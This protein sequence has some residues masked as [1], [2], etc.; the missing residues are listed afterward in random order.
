MGGLRPSSNDASEG[1]VRTPRPG[2][3][4]TFGTVAQE[5]ER[6]FLLDRAPGWLANC[7]STRIEQGYLAL[8]DEVEVRLRRSGEERML[9]V[10]RGR[11]EVRE[12]IE[13][14]LEGRQ[15]DALWPLTESRRLAKT[16]YVVQLGKD[17][18]AEVDVFEN[19]LEG[20]VLAEVEFDEEGGSRGFR[21]PAWVREEVTGDERYAGRSLAL[22]GSGTRTA[23]E[24]AGKGGGAGGSKARSYR[25][26]KKEPVAKGV[27]RIARGRA[28]DAREELSGAIDGDDLAAA[29]HAARKDMKKLRAVLRLVR[30]GLGDEVFRKENRR[31]RDAARLLAASRDA[32]VKVETLDALEERFDGDMPSEA[33]RRWRAT[34]E[35]EREEIIGA[36]QGEM[37]SRIDATLAALEAGIAEIPKWPLKTDSWELLEPGLLRSYRR[38]RREWKRTR[39]AASVESVHE[40]RKRVKDLWYQ[41]RIVRKAWPAAIGATADQAHELADLLGDHH[42]LA[43]LAD[44]L[45]GREAVGDRQALAALVERRQQELLEEALELAARLLAEKPKAFRARFKAYWQA[46]RA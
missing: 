12:E 9:A 13:V 29:I 40:W 1:A 30:D 45:Q 20:L 35:R 38:S 16:R 4:A 5:I 22:N 33:A 46:W 24:R 6:K 36:E 26:K 37:K 43:L 2:R 25:L 3:S 15:F 18:R 8:A 31:Y 23:S 11:G 32:E 27:R 39:S 28:E 7:S 14:A 17:L 19:D 42:D 34:L 41:L 44:D 10:K 21:P